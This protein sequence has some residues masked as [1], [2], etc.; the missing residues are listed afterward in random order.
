VR[1]FPTG[2]GTGNQSV[3]VD[4]RH[5]RIFV[6]RGRTDPVRGFGWFTADGAPLGVA[7]GGVFD[8][9]AGGLALYACGDGG[10]LVAADR[11]GGGTE[12]EV[13]DRQSVAHLGTFRLAD[14][15]EAFTRSTDGIDVLQTPVP[16]FPAGVLAA[17]HGCGSSQPERLDVVGWERVA[18]AMA[19]ETCP[20]GVPPDCIAAPCTERV[21]VT[22]DASVTRA[23]PHASFGSAVE[24]DAESDPPRRY[25]R[26]L[27]RFVVP[28]RPG[29]DVEGA[30]LRLTVAGKKDSESDSGGSVVRTIGDWD[31]TAVTYATRPR[32]HGRPLARAGAVAVRQAVDFDVS[33]AVPGGG[34]YDFMLQSPSTDR[35]R[36]RSREAGES[37]PTL[38][39]ALRARDPE[40]ILRFAPV[41]DGSVVAASPARSF[42]GRRLLTVAPGPHEADAFV[43]FAV[44]GTAGHAIARALLRLGIRAGDPARAGDTVF[45]VADAGWQED[46]LTWDARPPRGDPVAG[47]FSRHGVRVEFDVTSAVRGDGGVAFAVAATARGRVAYGS[48]EADDGRPEL[49][50]ILAPAAT[51]VGLRPPG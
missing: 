48:R 42:A 20:G 7:G 27:L 29:Y 47:T 51:S 15:G 14:A 43:R 34:T 21:L 17:C 31:E 1:T 12:F 22:A 13:F 26:T 9:D 33:D 25:T 45:A 40:R 36:Y 49:V 28:Q 44:S 5:E 11:V 10:Y 19:L 3:V 18:A 37:P 50:V 41:A 23:T 46:G 16:G 32:R 8:A 24:L 2:F 4:D 35:V 38:L 30:T 6:A 39:V